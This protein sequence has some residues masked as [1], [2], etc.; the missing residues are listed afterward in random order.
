M[1]SCAAIGQIWHITYKDRH[2]RFLVVDCA[3]EGWT[4]R[5]M[6]RNNIIVEID[7]QTAVRWGVVG[8]AAGP[9]VVEILAVD[10]CDKERC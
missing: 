8:K 10:E 3:G 7:Y 4:R 9:I 5:W 6:L 1:V 2:E